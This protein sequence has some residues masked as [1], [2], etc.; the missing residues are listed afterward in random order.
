MANGTISPSL[1]YLPRPYPWREIKLYAASAI[2]G[3][4]AGAYPPYSDNADVRF[5]MADALRLPALQ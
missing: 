2:K 5:C 3:G 4:C 1:T